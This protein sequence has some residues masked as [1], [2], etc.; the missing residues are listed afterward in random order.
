MSRAVVTGSSGFVGKHL[1]S[2]LAKQGTTVVALDVVA[3]AAGENIVPCKADLRDKASLAPAIEGADVVY[4]VASRVQTRHTG[5]DEVF[6]INVGGTRNLLAACRD[7]G[8]NKVVYVSSASVVYDGKD[9]ERGDEKL[10]YPSS[11]H[12]PYAKTKAV[13]EGEVLEADGKG[14]VRTCAIRPHVVF[15]PGDTRFLPAVLGRA[16]SG[17]LKAYVGSPEKL[18]DFTY[19]DNLVDGL[20]LAADKVDGPAGGQAYFVTNGEPMAFWEFIGRVL[21]G[22]GYPR[23]RYRVPFPIAYG[24][25]AVREWVDAARGIP[26]S[27]ESLTRFAIRYL[28]THHYF[29]HEKATKDLG[30]LPKVNLVEGIRRTVENL[31]G[32]S[33]VEASGSGRSASGGAGAAGSAEAP[34]A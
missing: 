26:T 7:K 12:A 20:L 31:K 23:P 11:F 33:G 18:S 22:L 15:G 4:H 24:A 13:A 29:S 1:T 2:T 10:A 8:V 19:V 32:T 34:A 9:V 14:G 6:E 3:G 27:E 28:T 25:A 5:A 30:Y 17:K 21:D 16:K